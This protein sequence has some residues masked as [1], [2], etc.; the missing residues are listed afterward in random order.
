MLIVWMQN[1]RVKEW[2]K[3]MKMDK[4][5]YSFWVMHATL[6]MS[7][8]LGCVEEKIKGRKQ[9]KQGKGEK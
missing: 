3:R 8:V 7:L 5:F 6:G 9:K 1:L 2:E 4:S